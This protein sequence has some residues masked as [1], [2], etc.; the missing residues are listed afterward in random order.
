MRLLIAT[1]LLLASTASIMAA[2]ISATSLIDAVTVY[3]LGA[4]VT[5][6]GRVTME[7]GE[8]VILF[9]DL[10]AQALPGSLR[11]EGKASGTLEIGS[12]DTRRVFVPRSDSGVAATERRQTEDAIEKLKDERAV[13]QTAVEAAQAR[14]VLI[15]NLG[16]PPMHPSAPTSA[17]T[18]PDWS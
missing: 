2:D 11:V 13:L 16:N 1:S 17:G 4:E 3:P 7:R 18:Q 5:R 8:H 14:K 6:I 9:T 10:P 15:N 12:V